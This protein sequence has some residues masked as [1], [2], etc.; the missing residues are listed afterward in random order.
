MMTKEME[1]IKFICD[2]CYKGDLGYMAKCYKRVI[3]KRKERG[4]IKE[5][6]V[7]EKTLETIEDMEIL[8]EK[9]NA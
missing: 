6:R 3:T 9:Q 2:N 7:L 8:T 4:D 1:D 5:I